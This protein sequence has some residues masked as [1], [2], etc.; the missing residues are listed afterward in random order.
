M[1]GRVCVSIYLYI[2][3]I[4]IY[5]NRLIY[6]STCKTSHDQYTIH[7][8]CRIVTPTQPIGR[9][10]CTQIL[11]A[12]SKCILLLLYS[13]EKCILLLLQIVSLD[14]V[15]VIAFIWA[16]MAYS[17]CIAYVGSCSYCSCHSPW[18][19]K[20]FMHLYKMNL[21]TSKYAKSVGK[22]F[23][24]SCQFTNVIDFMFFYY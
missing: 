20:P 18:L 8:T 10:K 7:V 12:I 19:W 13:Q 23:L 6:L 22:K 24:V 2:F 21:S 11:F 9:K 1:K 14:A 3:C 16:N 5:L 4:G 17:S 15:C